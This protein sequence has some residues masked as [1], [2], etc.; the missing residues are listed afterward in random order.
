MLASAGVAQLAEQRFRKAR[1]GGSTPLASFLIVS[2]ILSIYMSK[3]SEV[4]KN[5]N[6]FLLW[7]GQIISQIGDRLGL[8]ALIGF[9]YSKKTYGSPLELFKI[10]LFIIIPVFLISPVAGVYVDRWDRRRTLY[11]CDFIRTVLVMM[12]PLFLFHIKNLAFGYFLIFLVFCISRFFIPAKLAII[13]DLVPKKDLLMANSLVNIT[14][15]IAAIAGFGIS[16]ILVEW[17]G[18]ERGFYLDSLSFFVSAVLIFFVTYKYGHS[19]NLQELKQVIVAAINKPVFQEIKEG[20]LY[21]IRQKEIRFTAGVLFALSSALGAVSIVLIA[22]VQNTLHS[23]TRDLGFF[24]MFLGAGLFFGA[25]F[26]GRFGQRFSHYRTISIALFLTGGIISVSV[27][28][29]TRYQFFWIAALFAFLLGVF[30]SPV[31]VAANTIIHNVSDNEMMGKIFSSME[32]VMHLGFL[33]FMFISSIIAEKFSHGIIL[34]SVGC[35]IAILGVVGLIIN[36][37]IQWLN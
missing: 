27:L 21:F 3:F 5:R 2:G 24:I 30:F 11:M 26:Y 37:K 18:A 15:M 36:R 6:F 4:L 35:L 25:L 7:L 8:M 32:I 17:L 10:F 23:A 20:I 16:G 1:V 34:I 14:G 33:I 12:I 22:F 31:I 28:I 13:P 9:A 19:P 29:L